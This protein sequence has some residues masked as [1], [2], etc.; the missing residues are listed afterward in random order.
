MWNHFVGEIIVDTT[1]KDPSIDVAGA[2]L[3]NSSEMSR[4]RPALCPCALR[5]LRDRPQWAHLKPTFQTDCRRHRRPRAGR[6]RAGPA[7]A[8]AR[9]DDAAAQ[10]PAHDEDN[11]AAGGT[12]GVAANFAPMQPGG[13]RTQ[14]GVAAYTGTGEQYANVTRPNPSDAPAGVLR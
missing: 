12:A 14:W 9:A 5:I 4:N 7:V 11:N 1:N 3:V 10:M 8:P 13:V 2:D 6:R